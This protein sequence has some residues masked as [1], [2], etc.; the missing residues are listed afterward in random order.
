MATLAGR[1]PGIVDA[2]VNFFDPRRPPW[3]LPRIGR[4]PTPILR[5]LPDPLVRLA[6]RIADEQSLSGVAGPGLLSARY[7]M[8]EYVRD[9][10]G[11]AS[12]A[13]VPV[14]AVLP[15][16]AQWRRRV[17]I[18]EAPEAIAEDMR[19]LRELSY[20]APSPALGGLIVPGDERV[21]GLGVRTVLDDEESLIRGV[22][23]R[24]GR[25]PDPLVRDWSTEPD[26]LGSP[27]FRKAFARL[28][29]RGLIFE[30]LCYSHELAQL[31]DLASEFPETTIVV[32]HLGLPVGVFGPIGS[33]TGAT[34]AA[35]ADILS[36][37]RERMAMLAAR[38]NVLVKISGIASQLLGYGDEKAGNIGGQRILADM[39]GPLV[40][41]VVDRF[42]PERVIFGSNAPLDSHNATIGVTVG[43]LLDVLGPR[44]DYLLAHLFAENAQ[45]VYR[46]PPAAT[47]G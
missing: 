6:T 24:W 38:P 34:A 5:A 22:R 4:V 46:I 31:A 45:R 15:V 43:A 8:R 21:A 47:E 41:H 16:D 17:S 37:W 9:T 44:G 20:G 33:S 1:V 11:L 26:A 35:R 10:A 42:G 23:L 14:A 32:E 27:I 2:H 3:G 18:N 7:Q 19:T 12:V 13:G 36:L 25:H 29:E 40:L 39:I 28:A 30:S